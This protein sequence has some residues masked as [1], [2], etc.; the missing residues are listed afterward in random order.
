MWTENICEL[1]ERSLSNPV[2]YERGES[3][4]KNLKYYVRYVWKETF[5][6]FNCMQNMICKWKLLF[7]NKLY[8]FLILY[9]K[10][11]VLFLVIFLLFELHTNVKWQEWSVIKYVAHCI[12][13]LKIHLKTLWPNLQNINI[14][15]KYLQSFSVFLHFIQNIICKLTTRL[16]FSLYKTFSN[17]F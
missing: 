11:T 16:L 7:N 8:L 2:K 17:N 6:F 3:E 13:D 1:S 10:I 9:G 12:T 5:C 4:S 15:Y 14:Y